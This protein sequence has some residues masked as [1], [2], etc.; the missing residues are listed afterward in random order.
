MEC[1]PLAVCG[2]ILSVCL[3]SYPLGCLTLRA[4]PRIVS[5]KLRFG[6]VVPKP[7]VVPCL[8]PCVLIRILLDVSPFG[9]CFASSPPSYASVVCLPWFQSRLPLRRLPSSA[10]PREIGVAVVHDLSPKRPR[11]PRSFLFCV[12]PSIFP[13]SIPHSPCHPNV[14]HTSLSA[15]S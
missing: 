9:R 13:F 15:F 11:W 10:S 4:M 5:P 6:G 3:D 7:F 2:W 14:T 1:W 12:Q 8:F